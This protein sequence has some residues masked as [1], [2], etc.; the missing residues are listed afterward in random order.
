MLLLQTNLWAAGRTLV[1]P[2]IIGTAFYQKAKLFSN[3]KDPAWPEAFEKGRYFFQNAKKERGV[4]SRSQVRRDRS[5]NREETGIEETRRSP[6]P[7]EENRRDQNKPAEIKRY[8]LLLLQLYAIFVTVTK[9]RANLR[10][11]CGRT[12][13]NRYSILSK[14]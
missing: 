1:A 14:G 2:S 13:D 3:D 5:K 10:A 8:C 6:R 12:L 7:G 11:H 9:N 4:S